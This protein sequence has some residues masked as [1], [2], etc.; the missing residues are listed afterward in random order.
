LHFILQTPFIQVQHMIQT[1]SFYHVGFWKILWKPFLVSDNFEV[2]PGHDK[3]ER[4][5]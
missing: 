5:G 4:E 1:R 2:V 3:D